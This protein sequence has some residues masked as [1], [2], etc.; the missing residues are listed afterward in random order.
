MA[1]DGHC[2]GHGKEG[3]TRAGNPA[4]TDAGH[5]GS[6]QTHHLLEAGYDP[7]MHPDEDQDPENQGVQPAPT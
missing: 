2:S 1:R 7:V 3:V 6:R 5:I 4:D